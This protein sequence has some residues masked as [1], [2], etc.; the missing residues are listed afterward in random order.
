MLTKNIYRIL[1]TWMSICSSIFL[2]AENNSDH[3]LK[4]VDLIWSA[5]VEEPVIE[6]APVRLT[7][8]L[9]QGDPD[10]LSSLIEINGNEYSLVW[11]D[12]S[13]NL[14]LEPDKLDSELTLRYHGSTQTLKPDVVALWVSIIP[15]LVAIVLALVFREVITALFIGIFSGAA[16]LGFYADGWS[17]LFNGFLRCIDHYIL[18]ALYNTDHL[19]VIIFS[20]TIGAMVS[21]ISRNGGMM[22]IVKR[23]EP[24]AKNPRSGQLV[25]WTMGILIFFDDYANTLVVGNTMRP[26]ADRL[27]ISR[28]KLA[29]IV[30]S[31]AAPV[32]AIAFVTTWIGAELGYIQSGIN[33]LSGITE[34]AYSVFLNSLAYSF[35]PYFTLIFMLMLIWKQKDFGPMF[36]MEKKA[37]ELG[38]LVA[39]PQK[40]I[41]EETENYQVKEGIDPKAYNAIIPILV[42]VVGVVVGM[43][44]TGYTST[45]WSTSNIQLSLFRKLSLIVGNADSFKALLWASLG[46]ALIAIAMSI[47]QRILSLEEAIQ[48]GIN[49]FRSILPAM[50]ILTLAWGLSNITEEMHTADFLYSLW[51]DSFSPYFIPSIVF[52]LSAL[53]SF[54]TGSSWGTMAILYPLILPATFS[55]STNYGLENDQVMVIFYNVVAVILSG[56]VFG[57]HCSPISDTTILSS[58]ATSCNHIDHVRTQLPYAI[59]TG[60]ISIILGTLPASFGV[61]SW[62]L[63]VGGIA[64]LW[65][66]LRF[67]GKRVA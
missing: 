11:D 25:I 1:F 13:A 12:N 67:L 2:H 41:M 48:S 21:I 36:L 37:R 43:L 34:S 47:G 23:L 60:I 62:M 51:S 63:M 4:N 59:T 65:I 33:E 18:Q 7:F 52:I 10:M 46:G 40:D 5:N 53:V 19:S 3:E 29:Y 54:S 55:I 30:D 32:A 24:F 8:I 31:T 15:P 14:E 44:V 20:L 27:R 6:G 28:E 22:G 35:Y 16:I 17:G 64:L 42:T 38:V 58:L 56:S 66:T 45:N 39:R 57:D 9:D 26:M 50:I 49:G 61:P